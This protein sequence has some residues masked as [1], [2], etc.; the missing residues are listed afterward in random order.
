MK[1]P[2]VTEDEIYGGCYTM[3]QDAVW[4]CERCLSDIHQGNEGRM[5]MTF[6]TFGIVDYENSENSVILNMR[7]NEYQQFSSIKIGSQEERAIKF[8]SKMKQLFKKGSL[9]DLHQTPSPYRYGR[10]QP[11]GNTYYLSIRHETEWEHSI[12]LDDMLIEKYPLA[13]YIM[14][15]VRNILSATGTPITQLSN[16]Q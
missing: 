8:T 11:I 9:E 10:Y 5:G 2:Y 3:F 16:K 1:E 4:R 12:E 7:Y 6:A 14:R 15:L 13:N